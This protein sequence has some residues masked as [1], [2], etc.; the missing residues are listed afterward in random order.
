M[1]AVE[2]GEHVPLGVGR[3]L[4]GLGT[5]R[6]ALTAHLT[7][8][9]DVC[10]HNRQHLT[11]PRPRGLLPV[12]RCSQISINYSKSRVARLPSGYRAGLGRSRARVQ[13]AAATLSGNSLRQTV[14][15][16]RASVHQAAKLVAAPLRFARVLAGLA[17]SNGSLPPGL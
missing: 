16:H 9:L 5:K 14:H 8:R 3:F 7:V 15:T 13:I 17:E 4:G 11:L 12:C 2:D 1:L 6:L 10:T